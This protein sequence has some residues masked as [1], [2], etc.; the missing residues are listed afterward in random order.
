MPSLTAALLRAGSGALRGDR[1]RR[2]REEEQRQVM[3]AE[4]RQQDQMA[5][6]REMQAA[7]LQSMREAQAAREREEARRGQLDLRDAHDRGE[8][9]VGDVAR[10]GRTF[11]NMT[12]AMP[13]PMA[14]AAAG[15][16]GAGMQGLAA[17]PT[18]S[19]AGKGLVK[20]A[21]SSAEMKAERDA[22]AL[23]ARDAAEATRAEGLL[24]TKRAWDVED[25]E[26]D[27]KHRTGLTA[28]QIAASQERA[29]QRRSTPQDFTAS[30][31]LRVEYE[32]AIAPHR[33]VAQALSDLQ[34]SINAPPSAQG[35][36]ALTFKFM[37]SLDPTSTVREG[38]YATAKNAGSIPDRIKNMYNQARN[39]QFLT[40]QQRLEMLKV[41][42][43]R[44]AGMRPAVQREMQ[45]FGQ[46]AE[47]FGLDPRHVVFDPY[48]EAEEKV[49]T[50]ASFK[51]RDVPAG[52]S[53]PV[54]PPL[55]SYRRG[56]P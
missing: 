15:V 53:V 19:I 46:M 21:Q 41:A 22:K 17:K 13:T 30:R 56:R 2:D 12:A 35:D 25:R 3:V 16:L 47:E 34:A 33:G 52:T 55:T 7:S 20:V 39:G 26:D 29:G 9:D 45:R 11:S 8:R 1:T 27:Q 38:E 48:G 28:M 36:I 23:A 10:E 24:K 5:M 14:G 42:Q 18:Y 50:P 51:P 37:K 32:K 54:K 49:E 31:Q 44:A 6:Q 40:P 4:Q 43:G